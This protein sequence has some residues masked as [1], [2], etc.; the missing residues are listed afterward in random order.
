VR[1]LA[2]ET[3]M[4]RTSVALTPAQ[5]GGPPLAKRIEAGRGQAEQLVPLIGSLMEEASLSF[6]SLDRIAVCIG[7]GGFSG[8]RTG[9]A[10]ARGI[11]LAAKV[12]VAGATSFRIMASALEKLAE[13]PPAYGLAAPAGLSAVYCQILARDGH[14]VTE[15]AVL[16]QAECAA[17]FGGKAEALSGPAAAAL[18]E[19]GFVS[20]PVIAEGLHPDAAELA[21]MAMSLDPERDLPSPY[22]VREADAKPQTRH[23]IARK[24]E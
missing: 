18:R 19:A 3:S 14:P 20:L 16:P 13:V 21:A 8:I 24:P 6:A 2:I 10:A 12:P 11:G 15:I 9:V 17:F 5:A 23:V 4:G 7:P 1:I 22:Y